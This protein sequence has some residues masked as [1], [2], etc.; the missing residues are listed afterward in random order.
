MDYSEAREVFYAPS[1]T[2]S[3]DPEI[4]AR[5]GPARRLRD[6]Y[7]PIAMHAVWSPVT[8]ERLAELG[9]DFLN[10]YAWGRASG[11]GEPAAAVVVAAFAYFEPGLVTALYEQGRGT[12]SRSELVEARDQATAESLRGVLGGI[13]VRNVTAVLRRAIDAADGAGRPLFSGLASQD[14][15]SDPFGQ[16]WRACDIVREHRG[17]SHTAAFVSAGLDATEINVLTELW[18]GMPIFTYSATRGWPT[19]ALTAAAARLAARGLLDGDVLTA[20]GRRV[21]N[22]IEARTDLAQQAIVDAIGPEL[23][24]TVGQLEALSAACVEAKTFPPS[25]HKRAAG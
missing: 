20:E 2:G 15:P 24:A 6:A 11:M 25:P 21:R 8:N 4:V 23:D 16:L 9:L 1:P 10:G 22:E 3:V 17:D 13:D 18:L 7:E 12:V 14:W 19:E 5:G